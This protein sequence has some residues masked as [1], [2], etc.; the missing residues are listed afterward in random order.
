MAKI[1]EIQ[2]QGDI[3]IIP[4][5]RGYEAVIDVEDVPAVEGRFWAARESGNTVYAQCANYTEGKCKT[6]ILH[7][8]LL[9]APRGVFV[10]HR[11]GNGLNN[12]RSNLRFCNRSE[13][14]QNRDAPRN[15]LS[16]VKGVCWNVKDRRWRAYIHIA[17]AARVHLGSFLT[18]GEAA[19]A[20]AQAAIKYHGEFARV[21]ALHSGAL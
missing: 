17:P 12:R 16:G 20:Y 13:N 6:L 4:L 14:A 10:D 9:A 21:S 11:D 2:I 1:R 8:A 19:A 3:A 7:R 18:I 5:T 15:S